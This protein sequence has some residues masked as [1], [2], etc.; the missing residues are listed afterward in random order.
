MEVRIVVPEHNTTL[1]DDWLTHPILGT[2]TESD[3]NFQT[4]LKIYRTK[5]SKLNLESL[6]SFVQKAESVKYYFDSYRLLPVDISSN[7]IKRVLQMQIPDSYNQFMSF[8]YQLL[9]HESGKFNCL[10]IKGPPSVGKTWLASLV[11]KLIINTG[12][13]G[14]SNR[15]SQFPFQDCLR[16]N[17]LIFDEP[18]VEPAP[19]GNFKLLL[20]GTPYQ[21]ILNTKVET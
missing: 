18:N 14:N 20:S 13:I 10:L 4:A 2:I 21:Q 8:P 7:L 1:T 15:F 19:F 16:W 17:L 11:D 3:A 9:M 5:L 6:R 12:Y